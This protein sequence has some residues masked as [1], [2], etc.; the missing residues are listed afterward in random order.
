MDENIWFGKQ[1]MLKCACC[2]KIRP[3]YSSPN[4]C[5][6]NVEQSFIPGK[7]TVRVDMEYKC[8]ACG[9][10]HPIFNSHN[11]D[12]D[13]ESIKKFT[14]TVLDN[15]AEY[16]IKITVNPEKFLKL[17]NEGKVL[18]AMYVDDNYLCTVESI[19]DTC[20]KLSNNGMTDE[21]IKGLEKY[22]E[23][24]HDESFRKDVYIELIGDRDKPERMYSLDRNSNVDVFA[25]ARV[26]YYD[27]CDYE[28]VL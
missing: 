28:E 2:N 10:S 9:A 4:R 20:M 13:E 16:N 15:N 21:Q 11:V 7:V 6:F 22:L 18:V 17:S 23:L 5:R 8:M 24:M 26:I 1:R 27:V 12:K 25:Q 14:T 19:Y 3:H